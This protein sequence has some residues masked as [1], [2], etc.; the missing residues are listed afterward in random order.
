VPDWLAQAND[1]PAAAGWFV[2]PQDRSWRGPGVPVDIPGLDPGP[3]RATTWRG[4]RAL[5][6]PASW[7]SRPRTTRR[8]EI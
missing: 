3:R 7:S 2:P 8:W 1:S 4:P 5:R 6:S